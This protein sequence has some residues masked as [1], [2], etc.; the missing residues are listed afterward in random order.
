[1]GI[2]PKKYSKEQFLKY[3]EKNNVGDN[4]IR[5][6][7]KLP[8]KLNTGNSEYKLTIISTWYD[9]GNTYYNFE[10]NY[11]SEKLIEFLFTYKIFTDVEKSIDFLLFELINKNFIEK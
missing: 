5:K 7:N 1:M 9:I 10:L 11:Y 3:L 8:E 4:I 2:F 6:F